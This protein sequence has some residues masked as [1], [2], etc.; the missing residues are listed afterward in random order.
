MNEA[1]MA[2]TVAELANRW[3][4]DRKTVRRLIAERRLTAIKLGREW[5]VPKW[6][7]EK[8]ER[9]YSNHQTPAQR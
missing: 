1:D 6:S 7:I 9:L 5:R 8:Y 4:C 3:N 2:Y